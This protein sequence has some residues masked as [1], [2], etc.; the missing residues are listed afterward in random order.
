MRVRDGVVSEEACEGWRLPPETV[1]F[2]RVILLA[3]LDAVYGSTLRYEQDIQ[4]KAWRWFVDASADFQKVCEYAD[5]NPE[6]VRRKAI[7]Y[8]IAHRDE[9]AGKRPSINRSGI[10][11]RRSSGEAR[12]AA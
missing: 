6:T 4:A 8:I 2:R 12:L 11:N 3:V 10:V 5:W 7:D 9:A 1:L